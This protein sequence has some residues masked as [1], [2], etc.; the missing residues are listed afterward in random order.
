MRVF[1]LRRVLSG[2]EVSLVYSMNAMQMWH[3][4]WQDLGGEVK[5]LVLDPALP[6]ISDMTLDR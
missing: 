4:S 5:T 6:L 2:R 1:Q 3:L